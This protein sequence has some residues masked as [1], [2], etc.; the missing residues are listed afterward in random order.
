MQDGQ[1][2]GIAIGPDASLIISEI[3]LAAIDEA[4]Q[5]ARRVRGLRYIDDYELVFSSTSEAEDALAR[6]E[7]TLA[8]F[9]LDPNPKKTRIRQLPIPHEF[10]WVTEIRSLPLRNSQLSQ[11]RDVLRVFDTAFEYA[12]LNPDEHIL[13]YMVGRL[14]N[15]KWD[16]ANWALFQHLLLQAVVAEPATLA[17]ALGYLLQGRGEGLGLEEDLVVEVLNRLISQHA[18]LGHGSE[19]VWSLWGLLSLDLPFERDALRALEKTMDSTVV[20]MTL[21]ALALGRIPNPFDTT[22]WESVMTGDEL[23]ASNWLISYEARIKGWLPS[24]RGRDHIATNPSFDWLRS[25]GV[26][27]YDTSRIGPLKLTGVAPSIGVAPMFSL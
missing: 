7:Q 20:L 9:G 26:S 6:L 16:P 22:A 27:F 3:V 11:A 24:L 25:L 21:H 14:K 4:F 17:T 19:A 23:F 10:P 18:G 1:T 8:E 5:K 2:M 12:R 13:R 15:V